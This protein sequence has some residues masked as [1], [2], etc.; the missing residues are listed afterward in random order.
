[1]KLQAS[2]MPPSHLQEQI[3][4]LVRRPLSSLH[5]LRLNVLINAVALINNRLRRTVELAR[6]RCRSCFTA[7]KRPDL[8]LELRTEMRSARNSHRLRQIQDDEMGEVC[9]MHDGGEKYVKSAGRHT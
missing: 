7:R 6:H 9:S 5:Y 2:A 1:L 3:A 8:V 4:S